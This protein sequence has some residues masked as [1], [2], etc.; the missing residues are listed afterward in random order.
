MK[1][2]LLWLS[3]LL[4]LPLW[5][6]A[7]TSVP[8]GVTEVA[9][10][11][12][13]GT[14]IDALIVPASVESVGANVLAGS[15]AAYLYLEGAATR[16]EG[17]PGVPFVFGPAASAASGLSGFYATETLATDSG[18]YYAVTDTALPLCAKSPASLTGSVTIPK[19]LDGVPVT[20]LEALFL[21]NTRLTELRLPRYLAVP[22]GLTMTVTTYETMY[23]TAPV[24]DVTETPAGRY[25]TWTTTVEGA[26]GAVSYL[27][28]FQDGG[29]ENSLITAEP[30]VRYAPMAEGSCTATVTAIDALGD[31]AESPVSAAVTVTP[32]Q[33]KYRAL[34]I[35]NTYPGE[36]ITLPGCDHDVTSMLTVLNS[37][38][39]TPYQ[40]TTAINVTS[41]GI[42]GGIISAFADAQPGDVSLFYYSGH[43]RSD[44][45]LVGVGGTTVT[46]WALRNA[47][48]KIPGTKIVI[49]D[50]CYSGMAIS[51]SADGAATGDTGI[52][53]SFNSAVISAFASASRSADDLANQGYIVL[54]ACRKDQLSETVNAG[55]SVYF[56]AF[57]YGV[58]YGS[59]YDEW[60]RTSLVYL[61][62]DSNGDNR[63][64]LGEAYTGARERVA[65]LKT[66]LP[67]LVQEA[68][69]YGDTSFV[70]WSK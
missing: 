27:W 35:G 39:G 8:G 32:A 18:L 28:Y 11:A 63:I 65:Y 59:G 25:V 70:L 13:A 31:Q 2:I 30:T 19:L 61:P 26:Y 6:G 68:Q 29:E 48:Q 45:S 7:V 66:L 1:K 33:P 38:K 43:G 49:L 57:T 56:G 3:V 4:L 44:G 53:S 52:V 15:D 58:C 41:G 50:C 9:E 21:S 36:S 16:V 55:N 22:D 47:L 5:A 34:L 37:M 51:R 17:H 42:T 12:F 40:A 64:T 54:T 10:E 14:A 46:I 69:Y 20:S 24:A 62:A 23:V 60:Q 67:Q